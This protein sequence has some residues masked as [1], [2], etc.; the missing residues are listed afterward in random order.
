MRAQGRGVIP[1]AEGIGCHQQAL[2]AVAGGQDDRMHRQ[3]DVVIVDRAV[4]GTQCGTPGL[5]KVLGLGP[6]PVPEDPVQVS[7]SP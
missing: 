2:D 4:I 7:R 1:Q 3:Q 5:G 6:P